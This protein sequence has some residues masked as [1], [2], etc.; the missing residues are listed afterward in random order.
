MPVATARSIEMA[1]P[2]HGVIRQTPRRQ[3]APKNP[4]P[5]LHFVDE[6]KAETPEESYAKEASF[7]RYVQSRNYMAD[8]VTLTTGRKT[9]F[10]WHEAEKRLASFYDLLVEHSERFATMAELLLDDTPEKRMR[11]S[12]EVARLYQTYYRADPIVAIYQLDMAVRH[13]FDY[14]HL[15]EVIDLIIEDDGVGFDVNE[16][17]EDGRSHIGMENTKKRL[18]EMCGG[19]VI[20]ESEIGKGTVARVIIPKKEE[21]DK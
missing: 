7:E 3:S 11:S 18:H 6:S 8:F 13:R 14:Q 19:E 10:E 5:A 17:K 15:A 9:D 21:T 4:R 20:I 2:A 12:R 1:E 16:T